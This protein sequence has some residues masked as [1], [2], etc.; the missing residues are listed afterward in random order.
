MNVTRKCCAY[1]ADLSRRS[2]RSR[3]RLSRCEFSARLFNRCVDALEAIHLSEAPIVFSHDAEHRQ[4]PGVMT[5]K[6]WPKGSQQLSSSGSVVAG[7][8]LCGQGIDRR[9]LLGH[10][11]IAFARDGSPRTGDV[12]RLVQPVHY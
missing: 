4:Q 3:I 10:V 5:D 1:S 9:C 2:I 11:S 12:N 7:R 8:R 6:N